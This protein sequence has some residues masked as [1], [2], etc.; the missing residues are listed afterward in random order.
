MK[1]RDVM[2]ETVNYLPPTASLQDAAQEML[3]KNCGFLPVTDE[4]G[5]KL[6]GVITDRDI[7]VRAVAK[8][9]DPTSTQVSDILTNKVLY[10]FADDDLEDAADSMREQ[11]VYRLFVLDNAQ[12]KQ[13]CGV[14]SLGDIVRHDHTSLAGKTA[15][16][17]TSKSTQH[18][19]SARL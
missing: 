6:A 3:S 15:L 13:L 10:C 19:A 8:G 16:G 18:S 2:T 11:A 4:Q 17:I 1:V 12:D 9:K 7:T 14:A 5:E